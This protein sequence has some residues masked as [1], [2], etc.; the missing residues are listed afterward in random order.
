[1]DALCQGIE[2]LWA[3]GATAESKKHAIKAL[4]AVVPSLEQAVKTP[5]EENRRAMSVGAYYAGRAIDISKT[6]GPHAFSYHLT[7]KYN[8]PHG[9]AVGMMMEAFIQTNYSA[10]DE[11]LLTPIHKIFR[12]NSKE[13][14]VESVLSIKRN[15][16]QASRID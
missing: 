6:T 12:T 7:D 2:S 9:E 3:K 15:T 10:L 5:N 11:D 8:V 13:A 1:M 16:S 4:E 14:W